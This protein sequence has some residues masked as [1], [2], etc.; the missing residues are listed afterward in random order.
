[1]VICAF[2]GGNDAVRTLLGRPRGVPARAGRGDRLVDCPNAPA[3]PGSWGSGP[4]VDRAV[5][6]EAL[7]SAIVE[8]SDDA[9][10]RCDTRGRVV[11]WGTPS[12]RLFDRTEGEAQRGTLLDLVAVHL[13]ADVEAVVAQALE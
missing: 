4:V 8:T 11:S 2:S 13:R 9:V 12:S 3:V 6:A 10:F 5:S 1:M 7:V